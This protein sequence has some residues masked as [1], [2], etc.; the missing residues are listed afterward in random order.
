MN[1]WWNKWYNTS[2]RRRREFI[3]FFKKWKRIQQEYSHNWCQMN[4]YFIFLLVCFTTLTFHGTAT[5]H[6]QQQEGSLSFSK[7]ANHGAGGKGRVIGVEGGPESVVWVVQ[8]SDLH[9]SVHH[10][11]RALDFKRIVGPALSMINPSLVLITGDLTGL[12]VCF[13]FFCFQTLQNLSFFLAWWVLMNTKFECF[14]IGLF[15]LMYMDMG[16]LG[17]V[18]WWMFVNFM[19]DFLFMCTFVDSCGFLLNIW[20]IKVWKH[21]DLTSV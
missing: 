3:V 1:T 7:E 12:F 9:F 4:T 14:F 8:L 21:R 17:V 16:L 10:P 5:T 15:E 13:F 18:A 20:L 19:F 6:Q 11:D 2:T